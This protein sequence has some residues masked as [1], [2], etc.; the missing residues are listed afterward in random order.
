MQAIHSTIQWSLALCVLA[1]TALAQRLIPVT[2]LGRAADS[3]VLGTVE[4]VIARGGVGSSEASVKLTVMQSLKG[5]L[6]KGSV[7][8]SVSTFDKRNAGPLSIPS[9]FV[10]KRGLWFLRLVDGKHRVLPR[11]QFAYS[12]EE[13]FL[14][15][16]ESQIESDTR[17]FDAL[18]L[19]CQVRWYLELRDPS[20]LV[21]NMLLSSFSKWH[22]GSPTES[23][24]AIAVAP[25][26]QSFSIPHRIV[27]LTAAIRAGSIP[28]MNLFVDSLSEL[29]MDSK[30]PMLLFA[31]SMYPKDEKWRAPL[32]RLVK[33][34]AALDIPGLDAAVAGALSR[35]GTKGAMAM[36]AKLLDSKDRQAQ[37]AAASYFANFTFFADKDGV[38]AESGGAGPYATAETRAFTPRSTSTL[39]AADYSAYWRKWYAENKQRF[40]MEAD[41]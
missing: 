4:S 12:S 22:E 34:S 28:A 37:L 6:D 2:D 14:P 1:S 9:D 26:I 38:V 21:D 33:I 10:G 32:D 35:I 13:L 15:V 41:R 7:V 3:I 29:R 36:M 20:F 25:L 24:V 27:G 39:T 5:S 16:S 31:L 18:L 17:D 8:V 30:F 19:S 23:Q 40:V 11:A